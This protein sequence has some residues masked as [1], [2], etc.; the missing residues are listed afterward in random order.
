MSCKH[1]DR[2][3]RRQNGW[4]KTRLVQK[5]GVTQTI[6]APARGMGV[7]SAGTVWPQ[8][9]ESS[10]ARQRRAGRATSHRDATG[11]AVDSR[12]RT[13]LPAEP[14]FKTRIGKEPRADANRPHTILLLAVGGRNSQSKACTLLAQVSGPISVCTQFAQPV[15]VAQVL[16]A[17]FFQPLPTNARKGLQTKAVGCICQSMSEQV[18]ADMS[19]GGNALLAG[20]KPAARTIFSERQ[21]RLR[22]SA[23]RRVG[24]AP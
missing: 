9:G 19:I 22:A 12:R 17:F 15:S 1:R 16:H 10:F 3:S 18:V 20:S 24:Q 4:S 23:A 11:G 2:R 7:G 21:R 14:R 8:K 13:T 6:A 5:P